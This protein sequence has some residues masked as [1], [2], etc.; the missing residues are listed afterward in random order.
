[1]MQA[2]DIKSVVV[3]G[4]SGAIGTALCKQLAKSGIYVYAV[5]RPNSNRAEH[6][7]AIEG[8]RMVYCDMASY[9]SLSKMIPHVDAFFHLAWGKTTGVGRN[10]LEAQLQNIEHTLRA[11]QVAAAIG[12][13][14]FV[15]A[16]SQAE[17]GRCDHALT[18][19]TSCFPENGYGIAKLCAGQMSRLE[20]E[21][22]GIE[23]IWTRILSVYGPYDSESALISQLIHTLLRGEKPSLTAGKQIWDYLYADDAAEAL[24]LLAMYGK[25]GHVYPLGSG[26]SRP[27]KEYIEIVRDI[28]DPRLSLGFG[29]IPYTKGQVM[30]LE[31]DTSAVR[32]DTG[33]ESRTDFESGCR[34]TLSFFKNQL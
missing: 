1:M 7:K 17:Y 15:G 23:H 28:I 32:A 9:D 21:R 30:H 5:V 10:D 27:L 12:C 11:C 19:D 31:A 3:T 25:N 29:E 2:R 33:Y 6:L 16:G 26:H 14:V 18:P 34:A 20:C 22:L 8:I 24:H 4:P 13:K